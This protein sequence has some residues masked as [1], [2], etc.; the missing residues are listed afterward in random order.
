MTSIVAGTDIHFCWNMPKVN[1]SFMDGSCKIEPVTLLSSIEIMANLAF[2]PLIIHC[3]CLSVSDIV[4][5]FNLPDLHVVLTD[6]LTQVSHT[7]TLPSVGDMSGLM[8]I[9]TSR[10]SNSTLTSGKIF[11]LNQ[12]PTMHLISSFPHRLWMLLHCQTHGCLVIMM[13]SFGM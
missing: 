7:A 10:Y 3:T 1:S 12:K 11:D 9:L 2:I 6:Y 8:P 13:P 4:T 5:K